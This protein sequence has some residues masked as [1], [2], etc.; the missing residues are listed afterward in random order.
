VKIKNFKIINIGELKLN[1]ETYCPTKKIILEIDVEQYA[2]WDGP[3]SQE[4]ENNILYESAKNMLDEI[5]KKFN[6]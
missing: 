4:I 6:N 1:L 3:W 5:R 2:Q